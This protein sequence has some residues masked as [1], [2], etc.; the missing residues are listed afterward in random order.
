MTWRSKSRRI[1]TK[2]LIDAYNV[3]LHN[4]KNKELYSPGVCNSMEEY[5]RYCVQWKKLDT[6]EYI[7]NGS[8]YVKLE[9]SEQRLPIERIILNEKN[10]G[11]PSGVLDTS[12]I[13]IW[14]VVTGCIYVLKFNICTFKVNVLWLYY[15]Y[16]IPQ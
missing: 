8:I 2:V 11:E 15:V 16:F 4:N 9:K 10:H 13:L 5:Y 3:L 14:V 12:E 6:K 7:L 1:K